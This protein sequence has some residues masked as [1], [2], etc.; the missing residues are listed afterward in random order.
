MVAHEIEKDSESTHTRINTTMHGNSHKQ[1]YLYNL[2]TFKSSILSPR[3]I[4]VTQ[5]ISWLQSSV[6]TLKRI[7][8]FDIARKGRTKNEVF[9]DSN[10]HGPNQ[11]TT[12][13][14][15]KKNLLHFYYGASELRNTHSILTKTMINWTTIERERS[16]SVTASAPHLNAVI[17]SSISF[18]L[19]TKQRLPYP[20]PHA[21]FAFVFPKTYLIK[22]ID[23]FR[24]EVYRVT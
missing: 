13:K 21:S 6:W 3:K 24:R 12:E 10:A 2:I 11:N 15:T 20:F 23:I 8:Q 19:T 1:N 16:K 4:S 22:K 5:L 14:E 9:D 7:S 17:V 18:V